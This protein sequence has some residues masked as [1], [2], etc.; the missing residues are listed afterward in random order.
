MKHQLK[1][2]G[3]VLAAAGLVSVQTSAIPANDSIIV[4]KV[5]PNKGGWVSLFDGK[6]LKGWHGFNKKGPVKNWEIIDGALVARVLPKAIPAATL[7]PTKPTVIL[8]L[9]GNGKL[10]KAVTAAYYTT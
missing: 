2:I 6:S 1:K 7:L 4:K 9:P 3:L 10:T 8:N 5:M